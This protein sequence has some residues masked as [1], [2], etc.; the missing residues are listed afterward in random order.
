MAAAGI[1]GD[2]EPGEESPGSTGTRCRVTPGRGDP[3]ESATESKPPAEAPPGRWRVR[4]KGCGKSAPRP[5]RRGRQGK[6]HREQDQVGAAGFCQAGFRAAVRVGRTRRPATGVP[7]EWPSIRASKRGGQN[8]AYRPSGIFTSVF[9]DALVPRPAQDEEAGPK[10]GLS[11]SL[12]DGTTPPFRPPRAVP[13][14][15]TMREHN[16]AIVGTHASLKAIKSD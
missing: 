15:R 1:R 14:I 4:V 3:R 12:D 2:P 10:L 6:P 7:D 8:P 9:H 5:R 16:Y 11:T 13:T